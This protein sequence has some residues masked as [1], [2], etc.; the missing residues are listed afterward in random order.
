MRMGRFAWWDVRPT[1]PVTCPY[2][3]SE[4]LTMRTRDELAGVC[5]LWQ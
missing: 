4:L 3:V 2:A 5:E 1:W